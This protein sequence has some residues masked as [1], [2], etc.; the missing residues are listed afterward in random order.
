VKDEEIFSSKRTC[1]KEAL[2]IGR[3]REY[4]SQF[5]SRLC[6]D[7]RFGHFLSSEEAF[8][9]S[10]SSLLQEAEIQVSFNCA[11]GFG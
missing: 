4:R 2:R 7:N 1:E 8:S 11:T 10:S 3:K 6:I 5:R 9:S